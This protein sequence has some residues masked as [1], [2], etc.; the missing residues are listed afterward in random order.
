MTIRRGGG[1][2]GS[3]FRWQAGHSVHSAA[4][5]HK[6]ERTGTSS[7]L[8]L[9]TVVRDLL[10][11]SRT[12]PSRFERKVGTPLSPS[13]NQ[14]TPSRNGAVGDEGKAASRRHTLA[15]LFVGLDVR[16]GRSLDDVYL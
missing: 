6:C 3:T 11:S 16:C 12:G 13:D 15:L 4:K 7:E 9:S 1:D 5:S 8:R 14:R 2:W 10:F